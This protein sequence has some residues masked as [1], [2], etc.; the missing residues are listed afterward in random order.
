MKKFWSLFKLRKD[1][2]GKPTKL[3][4]VMILG[5]VGILLVLT[6][7][8]FKDD[9][10]ETTPYLEQ[11]HSSTNNNGAEQSHNEPDKT[12]IIAEMEKSYE[13]ELNELLKS[14][15]GVSNVD[16]MVNLDATSLKVYEKNTT[17]NEQ[18]TEETDSN[19]GDRTIE[20]LSEEKQTVILRSQNDESPLLI[21]TKKPKVRG[22]LI[23]G[24]GL[25]NLQTEEMVI[26]AVSRVLD[27][28]THRIS[29]QPKKDD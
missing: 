8:I 12:A 29:V 11:N 20:E 13:S 15:E 16:V 6:S 4:Y 2:N 25:E 17:T 23:V 9:S 1:E 3:S 10:N 7:N 28:P 22:V 14:M 5:L 24:N 18:T 21:Q 26:E 19:G 27:V